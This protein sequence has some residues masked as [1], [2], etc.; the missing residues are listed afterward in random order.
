MSKKRTKKTLSTIAKF[1]KRSCRNLLVLKH[2]W[3]FILNT[4][5]FKKRRKI[6]RKK[7]QKNRMFYILKLSLSACRG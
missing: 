1:L 5:T 7:T 2:E 3:H 4:E 6:D